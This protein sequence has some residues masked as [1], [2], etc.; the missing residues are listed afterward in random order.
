MKSDIRKIV[1]FTNSLR[2]GGAERVLVNMSNFLS[3]RGHRIVLM[4][5]E[6]AENDFFELH[7]SIE[8]VSLDKNA[9]TSFF[10]KIMRFFNRIIK[11]KSFI[12][13]EKPDVIISFLENI[14][15]LTA[16]SISIGLTFSI[17]YFPARRA[18]RLHPVEALRYE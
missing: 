3:L 4:T 10:S 7:S 1:F 14:N 12:K 15:I 11:I 2:A 9:A 17:T 16:V 6:S 8:R 5:T 18:A 13:K